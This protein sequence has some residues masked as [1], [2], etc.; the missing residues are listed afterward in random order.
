MAKRFISSLQS[1]KDGIIFITVTQEV[2]FS[3]LL[4]KCDASFRWPFRPH[5]AWDSKKSRT[6]VTTDASLKSFF[7]SWIDPMMTYKKV[8]PH[9]TKSSTS[10]VQVI[11]RF[12]LIMVNVI[13]NVIFSLVDMM[14]AIATV[15]NIKIGLLTNIKIQEDSFIKRLILRIFY[16]K[17]NWIWIINGENGFHIIHLWSRKVLFYSC[18]FRV[19]QSEQINLIDKIFWVTKKTFKKS[20]LKKEYDITSSHRFRTKNNIQFAFAYFHYLNEWNSS[21][22]SQN[23]IENGEQYGVYIGLDHGLKPGG[24]KQTLENYLKPNFFLPY[25]YGLKYLW[26]CLNDGLVEDHPDFPDAINLGIILKFSMGRGRRIR[27]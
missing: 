23:T 1:S 10:N 4:T 7:P 22:P 8:I 14:M 24:L 13:L 19:H 11:V 3:E 20:K 9:L 25:K 6:I 21:L 2:S 17:E 18:R 5:S 27:L 26:V 12:Y 15:S 16:S